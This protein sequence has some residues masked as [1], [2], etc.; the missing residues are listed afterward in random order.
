MLAIVDKVTYDPLFGSANFDLPLNRALGIMSVFVV[1]G[2]LAGLA[3][4]MK[5]MRIKPV[6]AINDK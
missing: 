6:E 1:F 4:S 2:A 3:P 5:A